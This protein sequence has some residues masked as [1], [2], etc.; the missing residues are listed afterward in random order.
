[1]NAV[2]LLARTREAALFTASPVSVTRD[3]S[4]AGRVDRQF[5]ASPTTIKERA[6]ELPFN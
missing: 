5:T 1:M 4:S 3:L 6:R 2:R